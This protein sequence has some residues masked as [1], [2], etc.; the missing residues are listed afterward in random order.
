MIQI[1]LAAM[2]ASL[3]SVTNANAQYYYYRSGAGQ[4]SIAGQRV[5]PQY[6]PSP[7]S[8]L[9]GPYYDSRAPGQ[10]PIA[11]Q[12]VFPQYAPSPRSQLGGPYY[13]RAPGQMPIA[14]QRVFPQY[15]PPPQWR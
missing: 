2:T 7:R 14:G 12:R 4:M 1:A 5:F 9:G 3:I 6:A 15:A 13:G 11:G 10:M 8:Q